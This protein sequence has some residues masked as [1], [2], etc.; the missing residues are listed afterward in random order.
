MKF[1][2]LSF[3]STKKMILVQILHDL[4]ITMLIC[5]WEIDCRLPTQSDAAHGSCMLNLTA[6]T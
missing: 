2:G 5:F 3:S 4:N 1:H 6:A